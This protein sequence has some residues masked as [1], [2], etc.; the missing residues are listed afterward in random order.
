MGPRVTMLLYK[1][2]LDGFPESTTQLYV[3]G[4]TQ[5]SGIQL[6]KGQIITLDTYFN[7]F[8]CSKFLRYTTLRRVKAQL[9]VTGR[10]R[11]ELFLRRARGRDIR[12]RTVETDCRSTVTLPFDLSEATRESFA[13]LKVTALSD[14]VAVTGGRYLTDQMPSI[15]VRLA[16]L[17]C[18][19]HREQYLLHN[20]AAIKQE[21]LDRNSGAEPEALEIFI[22]DN[23]G[24]LSG[25]IFDDDRIHLL[26]SPNCGGSGGF[27]RSL[28]E[29]LESGEK[30]HL[31]F[32][33]DDIR[34][35][36]N[37]ITKIIS[38]L[39]YA[40]DCV[41]PFAIAGGMLSLKQPTLQHEAG[42]RWKGDGR[43][44]SLKNGLDLSQNKN[45]FRNEKDKP[46]DYGGWWCFAM[47]TKGVKTD[48]LPL[49]LFLK[50][51]DIEFS[52]RNVRKI[53]VMNGIG[54]WHEPFETKM[55][56]IT[57]YYSIRNELILNAIYPKVG[58]IQT[59][60]IILRPMIRAVA[61]G[62]MST[63]RYVEQAVDDYL[64][65][66]DFF[67]RT[68][69]AEYHQCL[70]KIGSEQVKDRGN[71][72]RFVLLLKRL[73]SKDFAQCLSCWCKIVRKYVRGRKTA[74]DSF[75]SRWPELTTIEFWSQRLGMTCPGDN[76]DVN[77]T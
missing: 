59:M 34:L 57:D 8:S 15:P 24:T 56:T 46:A 72:Q 33:D 30:T 48:N 44:H 43:L 58:M 32:M 66:V 23:G 52:L 39:R 12:L 10:A 60:W 70:R 5:N 35:D 16:V 76:L 75:S 25:S 53:L 3:R 13:Y 1:I 64:G 22:T 50:C 47:S 67:L 38:L 31:L 41:I 17:I 65:G 49:P 40:K 37:V 27:T 62:S 2:V 55:S 6:S 73:F 69:M 28:I 77:Q 68:D 61:E 63:I 26:H 4:N 21:L 9:D 7:A 51:D 11:I 71:L 19:F 42:A 54:V 74:A 18:T 29:A 45:L 14:N 36:A 20:L